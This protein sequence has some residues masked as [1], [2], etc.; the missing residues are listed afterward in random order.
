MSERYEVFTASG[1]GERNSA[2]WENDGSE[3]GRLV[4]GSM[5][6]SDAAMVCA[7][8]NADWISRLRE[9]LIAAKQR[10]GAELTRED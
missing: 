9:W 4:A 2:V 5:L 10:F 7:L 6:P 8:L 1:E 3:D